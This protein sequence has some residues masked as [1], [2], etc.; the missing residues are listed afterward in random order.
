MRL[1]L[2]AP[3]FAFVLTVWGCG[4]SE[5]TCQDLRTCDEPAREAGG[6]SK[7][8]ADDR[9]TPT[10]VTDGAEPD[11]EAGSSDSI[12][13][14]GEVVDAA[15]DA[16]N[17]ASDVQDESDRI[18]AS[19]D[20]GCPLEAYTTTMSGA[21]EVPP[22]STTSIG[23]ARVVLGCDGVTITYQLHLELENPGQLV[24]AHFHK[25]VPGTNGPP[26]IT[27]FGAPSDASPAVDSSGM[28]T[29]TPGDVLQLRAGDW[30]VDAHTQ[31]HPSGE[32]RG[33]LVRE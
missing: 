27:I 2:A 26:Y 29:L 33:W 1:L 24:S 20:R 22:V 23:T 15:I 31:A 28:A 13:G 30:Y 11:L 8:A 12:D 17:A 9:T 5:K 32:I 4:G 3:G 19:A 18:E 14:N 7:E 6:D 10:D 16:G 25:A 21:N